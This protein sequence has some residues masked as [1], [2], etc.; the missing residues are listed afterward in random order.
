MS[1]RLVP[2]ELWALVEPLIPEFTP[3]P[4]GGGTAPLPPRQV[5]TAIV[6]V[7]TSGCAWRDLPPS[8]G[9]PFQTAHRRFSQWTEAGLWR[10]LHHAVLD[11]L[12]SQGSID[13][14]RAILDGA[15]VRAKKGGS[16]TGPNPVDRGKPGSKIHVLPERGG[17]PISLAVSA[18]NT[19]DSQ[20]LKPLVNAIPAIRSRRGPRRHKPGKLHADKAYD[21]PDL[22]R[23]VRSRGIGVRIARKGI[24]SS[25]KL[26]K[27]RW[28]IERTI[29]WL[30]GYRRLTIRYE[31]KATHFL[32]FLTLG[33]T[34]TCFKKLHK[35]AT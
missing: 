34:L 26:G 1:L 29:A 15:S 32:A 7:L 24:E 5:F 10:G 23:W 27:H 33:A 13:W 14:S 18:A 21:Q 28:V 8:F 12:G 22:R 20:A 6:Y 31:R 19:H 4:Q 35:H 16:L 9:V 30:T 11:E 3:R 17:L 2:D 25:D